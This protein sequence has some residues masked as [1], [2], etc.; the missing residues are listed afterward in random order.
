MNGLKRGII[1]AG[2]LLSMGAG[3]S[4]DVEAFTLTN[5][6]DARPAVGSDSHTAFQL[7]SD[8]SFL[9][10]DNG[11]SEGGEPKSKS[12]AFM[13]SLLLP[14]LGQRYAGDKTGARTFFVIE[15]AI[16]TSFI[17]FEVQGHVR[18]QGYQDFAGVFAGVSGDHSDDYYSIISEY[19]SWIE[20]EEAIKTEGRFSLYPEGDAETLEEYFVQNR[21]SDYE[22]WL[23][24]SV[25]DRRDFR[26]RRSS[27][28]R[29]YR[30]AL[31]AVA[32]AMANRAA[33]AFFAIKATN[34][35]NERLKENR[36]GY[37]LEFGAPVRHPGDAFQTGVS[38]VATF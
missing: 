25:D 23:W 21:V 9:Q 38:L 31:Y 34:D 5:V 16:W 4:A 26:S 22:P 12:K 15:A 27:S 11:G 7:P 17:V 37:R 6:P 20:Y 36:I 8:P 10:T 30:R 28:E 35:A 19:N 2:L 13:Y 18:E 32:A 24:R 14:G 3:M 29:S 1:A 33:S